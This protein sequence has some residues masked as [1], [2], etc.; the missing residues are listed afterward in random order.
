MFWQVPFANEWGVRVCLALIHSL[1]IVA[2]LALATA[3]AGRMWLRARVEWR[4]VVH[5]AALMFG[6]AALPVTFFLL[7]TGEETARSTIQQKVAET[8]P[9]SPSVESVKSVVMIN[10]TEAPARERSW[11]QGTLEAERVNE[12]DMT[13][14][15]W[16]QRIVPWGVGLYLAGVLAMC[17]RLL[18]G[19]V[20]VERLRRAARPVVDRATRQMLDRLVQ[21]WRLRCVP[22]IAV[23]EQV[24][25][26][27][28]VGLVRPM[29]FLPVSVLSGL[30]ASELELILA[31]E[32]AHVWR[33]DLWVNLLQR[34]AET[35]LFFNPAL[36]YLSRRV[37][38]LREYCCDELVCRN[39]GTGVA[40]VRSEYALALVR[41]VELAQPGVA[42]RVGLLTLAASGGSPSELRRR[43]ARLVG[44][45]LGEPLR[46]SRG[47]AL[48][49]A[50]AGSAILLAAGWLHAE[51]KA[52]GVKGDNGKK[53][54][55]EVEVAANYPPPATKADRKVAEAR[56][57]T[58]GLQG[59]PRVAIRQ[60]YWNSNVSS[61]KR[62]PEASLKLMWEALGKDVEL[63]MQRNTQLNL[64]LA[65]DGAKFVIGS[66][67]NRPA[68]AVQRAWH[69]EQVRYWNGQEGRIGEA[70]DKNQNVY[71]YATLDALMENYTAS[72]E[73]PQIAA[74]GGRVPW[75]GPAIVIEELSVDPKLTRYE[76]VGKE[77]VV[78][79][80]C[81]VY[82][83]PARG[84]RLW[85]EKSTG[86]VKAAA[87]YYVHDTIANYYT[88]LIRDV[89]GRTFVDGNEYREWIKKQSEAVQQ[90]MAAHWSATYWKKSEPGNLSVFSDYREI[91]PG[92]RWPM[93]C[94]RITVHPVGNG[95]SNQ[96][97]YIRAE[98]DATIV[99]DG[100]STDQLAGAA[101]LEE[102]VHVVDRRFDPEIDYTWSKSIGDEELKAKAQAKLKLK[103]DKEAEERRINET[104]INSV[105][106]AIGILTEGPKTDPTKVWVRAI[107]YLVDHK[108]EA[109]PAVV[110]QLDS[111]KRDHPISKLAF[112]L[113]AMGDPRAVPVL[114]R[115]LPKTLL[116]S[117]SDYGLLLDD[118]ALIRFIQ[119]NDQDGKVRDG[120][121]Y[122]SYGRAFREVVSALRRLSGQQ[123]NEMEL[124][125]VHL[126]ESPAQQE[127]Q[128]VLFH[129][130]AERWATWWEA[131][132]KGL[133]QDEAFSK[134]NLPAFKAAA[135]KF[136]GRKEPP[137]GEGVKLL[138]GGSGWIVQAVTE[139]KRRCF[140]DLDTMREG[141]WPA[142][143]GPV[144][145][146]GVDS[147]EVLTW[148]RREGY[149]MVGV[150]YTPP[151]ETTPIYALKPLDMHV[152]KI[153]KDELR[154]LPSAMAGKEAYPLSH[155][156]ELMVPR[157]K[158][159]RPYDQ[160]SGDAFLFVTREGTAGVIR[161][162]A[163][164]T[165]VRDSV[166]G[167]VAVAVDDEFQ[168]TG[169]YRG[170]KIHIQP[171]T[172]PAGA[173]D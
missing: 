147:P 88:E 38:A 45:P 99:S 48:A 166:E 17:V 52:G 133:T 143:L 16:R 113:R 100:F 117:R 103:Q 119:K 144:E 146:V 57:R 95:K 98:I 4:Y 123:F 92:V 108:E 148:A 49:L 19:V 159:E 164:V 153:T 125:W 37:S 163:Q 65:W 70:S 136:A 161:M 132:W 15:G 46:L 167:Y 76:H 56:K 150:Q 66:A 58:F 53:V 171:M 137:A 105:A 28:V 86:L 8:R 39:A 124:N 20:A 55:A 114:I 106:D 115:A 63:E 26:P 141:G 22:A 81:D 67:S 79:V 87:R 90:K 97:Q 12:V 35:V 107:K 6:L 155:P 41:V 129:R 91:T 73:F 25:V 135:S 71:R 127:Q 120:G 126:A 2:A 10:E 134:V 139:S 168:P 18:V 14:Q 110:K 47:G 9:V 40:P 102:G 122:F 172:E 160:Y 89:V 94:E 101:R 93:H 75:G 152:W 151:D 54:E 84:E 7:R 140:V 118:P 62:A 61:M 145:K 43:V 170:A 162:T 149:D 142:E 104:P 29:I 34:L 3:V 96:Y 173:G 128:R 23:A 158:V 27:T 5:V 51:G 31:H 32:L 112:A 64:L 21:K 42:A 85:I 77:V 68:D 33:Y 44:E 1:W 109:F 74:A 130:V 156:T 11:G 69:Y 131:N 80:E 165:E 72:F 59:L 60:T 78:G 138:D 82:E 13:R 121:N 157:R 24:A 36:W 154:Q 116:P 111:E 50:L 83:G 169:V 30:S